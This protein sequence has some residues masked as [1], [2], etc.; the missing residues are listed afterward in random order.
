MTTIIIWGLLALLVTNLIT[1]SIAWRRGVRNGEKWEKYRQETRVKIDD[2]PYSD[3][4]RKN[5]LLDINNPPPLAVTHKTRVRK[6]NGRWT[7]E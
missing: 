3:L 7:Y 2:M 6:I 4:F 5:E 1:G